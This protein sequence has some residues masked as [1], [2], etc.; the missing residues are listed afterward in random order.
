MRKFNEHNT[1]FL[2]LLLLLGKF[3]NLYV[4]ISITVSYIVRWLLCW[5]L[6]M[7]I[8]CQTFS[9]SMQRIRLS[10]AIYS[11]NKISHCIDMARLRQKR[12]SMLNC[13]KFFYPIFHFINFQIIWFLRMLH[14]KQDWFIFFLIE[15]RLWHRNLDAL[16]ESIFAIVTE[17]WSSY[18][19]GM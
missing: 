2:S 13:R 14:F 12:H 5:W 6:T 7:T 1:Y 17:P 18:H 11:K 16:N 3:K 15:S 8:S 4:F 9:I 19:W 10:V